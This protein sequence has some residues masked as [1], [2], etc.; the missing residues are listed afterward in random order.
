ME[1]KS[2][3]ILGVAKYSLGDRIGENIIGWIEIKNENDIVFLDKK[4]K[5]NNKKFKGI[6]FLGYY[7]GKEL[8]RIKNCNNYIVVK[9]DENIL[10]KENLLILEKQ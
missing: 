6:V 9:D 7:D 8:L 10:F 4:I 3:E 1:I 5:Y 2:I